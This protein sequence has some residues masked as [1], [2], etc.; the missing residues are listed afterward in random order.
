MNKVEE[1]R[2][3]YT[4]GVILSA[5]PFPECKPSLDMFIDPSLDVMKTILTI[6]VCFMFAF[7]N[8]TNQYLTILIDY[9]IILNVISIDLSYK[10]ELKF[11][12]H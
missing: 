8:S 7:F 3:I 10:K 2:L 9:R 1:L 5:M 11:L 6:E 4:I 12:V